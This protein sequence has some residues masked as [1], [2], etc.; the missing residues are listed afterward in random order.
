VS[1]DLKNHNMESKCIDDNINT[2]NNDKYYVVN[3]DNNSDDDD[4]RIYLNL[5]IQSSKNDD[6]NERQLNISQLKH[7][8]NEYYEQLKKR[9][10]IQ[11]RIRSS[12]QNVVL[13]NK[14]KI[15]QQQQ[16]QQ[17]RDYGTT[18]VRNHK[19]I[20]K[21]KGKVQLT[22]TRTNQSLSRQEI[23]VMDWTDIA[24]LHSMIHG[25]SDDDDDDDDDNDDSRM[26]QKY[27]SS[28]QSFVITSHDHEQQQKQKPPILP[29][30]SSWW[31][32][33]VWSLSW[34]IMERMLVHATIATVEFVNT[35]L[36]EPSIIQEIQ[37][38]L[39]NTTKNIEVLLNQIHSKKN[40]KQNGVI[41]IYVKPK[42]RQT[43]SSQSD[44]VIEDDDDDKPISAVSQEICSEA[45]NSLDGDDKDE[46]DDDD[47]GDDDDNDSTTLIISSSSAAATTAS[48][49]PEEKSTHQQ[50]NYE[51][52]HP[53][54]SP[55]EYSDD[56][57]KQITPMKSPVHC[58]DEVFNG[59]HDDAEPPTSTS[60]PTQQHD[61]MN[62][63]PSPP[64]ALLVEGQVKRKS[65]QI[66]ST[67][68]DLTMLS[69]LPPNLRAEAR[70]VMA[71]AKKEES[72]GGSKKRQSKQQQQQQIL[73]KKNPIFERWL[74]TNNQERN[75]QGTEVRSTRMSS[76]S[77]K[78]GRKKQRQSIENYF[79]KVQPK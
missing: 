47:A 13:E 2:T 37:F 74:S 64:S 65:P 43:V 72:K 26:F 16:Q 18:T 34:T 39:S 52:T 55:L 46:D 19:N 32:R 11:Q 67:G 61:M 63:I 78:V 10:N 44:K 25:D 7:V 51:Q 9:S 23:V 1:F 24:F 28:I 49:E 27:K 54:Q 20:I 75:G 53:N 12:I 60:N 66:D 14:N 35:M 45:E 79:Q 21:E 22:K 5:V 56:G 69:Q 15:Q 40:N 17:Q 57:I 62:I 3:E 70:L 41:M 59:N 4:N 33:P 42:P 76:P 77:L 31:D 36:S 50:F 48:I 38:V 68:L 73:T 58:A 6:S 71:L 29:L 8:M 30:E